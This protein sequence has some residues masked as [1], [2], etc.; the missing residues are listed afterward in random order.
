MKKLNFESSNPIINEKKLER[1]SSGAYS[2]TGEEPMTISGAVNKSIILFFIL[3]MTSM[4]SFQSPSNMW[5]WVGLIGG[6]AFVL[7]ASFKP[8][9]SYF[10]APLYAGFEGLALGSL[11]AI[12]AY[13]Y[14]GIVLQA[15]M[16]TMACLISMLLIYKTGLI[17]VNERFRNGV[18]I[19]TG[20]IA[21][22]YLV[23]MVGGFFGWNMPYIHE[24]GM[25]GIGI[26][27]V[28]IGV[29]AM[30]LL[31]DFDMFERAADGQAPKYMEWFC[32]L[33]LMVTLVWLYIEFLRLLS[34][35]RD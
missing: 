18:M 27:V 29:A 6:L 4:Y 22:V 9:T 21:L 25:I 20:A 34:K 10:A 1:Y 26:S 14:D 7:L 32:A 12:Y 16:L 35:L 33:G 17:K 28:I 3:L 30:N 8:S 13:E 31:L 23:S 24:G 5:L 11:S 15:F 2:M 19:A